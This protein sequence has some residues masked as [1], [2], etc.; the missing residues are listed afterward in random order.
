MSASQP[1]N[2]NW[3]RFV[4]PGCEVRIE[5]GSETSLAAVVQNDS[6]GGVGLVVHAAELS[7]QPG[8]K[9]LI[10]TLEGPLSA[11]V[12]FVGPDSP[13]RWKLGL[14]WETPGPFRAGSDSWV[15]S[16]H[17]SNP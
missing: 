11:F 6:F 4:V 3:Q 16:D 8:D 5:F 15:S 2:R 9:I 14:E 13:Q 17:Q 12:R 1:E 10:H 7:V